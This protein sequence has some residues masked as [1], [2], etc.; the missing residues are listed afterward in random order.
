MSKPV[1]DKLI[2]RVA[3]AELALGTALIEIAERLTPEQTAQLP[4]GVLRS[5]SNILLELGTLVDIN[6]ETGYLNIFRED[7]LNVS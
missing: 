7:D 5:W 4:S 3:A 2:K 1:D 6:S